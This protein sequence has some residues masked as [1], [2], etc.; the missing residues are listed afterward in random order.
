MHAKKVPSANPKPAQAANV[1]RRNKRTAV[2]ARRPANVCLA[3][4]KEGSVVG[5]KARA[6]AALRVTL[7]VTVAH[8]QAATPTSTT[9]AL[10][11]P[12]NAVGLNWKVKRA[13][14]AVVA[15]PRALGAIPLE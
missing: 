10:K 5:P 13:A 2:L 12:N 9:R 7:M 6:P 3:H 1:Q 15:T 11:E 14:G 8:V 4:A